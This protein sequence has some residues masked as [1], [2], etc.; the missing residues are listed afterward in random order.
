[1]SSLQQRFSRFLHEDPLLRRVLKNTGYLFTSST[2]SMVFVAVQSILAARLLGVE[3]LGVI[4]VAMTFVT[5][6][7]QLFSFRMGE[8]VVRYFG[9]AMAEGKLAHASATVKASAMVEGLTSIAAFGFL[10]L[11]APLG[12]RF[13]AKD[14]TSLILFQ[15]F[16]FAILANLV[17]ETANGVLRVLNHYKVQGWIT[18]IQSVLT[19]IIITLAFIFK[20]DVMTILLAYLI[21]KIFLGFSPVIAA[22][23][24]MRREVDPCWWSA[25]LAILPAL[26]DMTRFAISTNLSGTLKLVVSES[27]PFWVGLLLNT[28]AV[29]LYKVALAIVG[30]LIIPV[31]PFNFT[32]FP[33]ITRSV[34]SKGWKQ[35]RRLLKRVSALSAAWTI[36]VTLFMAVFGK[37][38]IGVTYGMEFKP[39][40][41][42]LMILLAGFG[43]SNIFFWNRSLLLSFGN[44]HVPLY[45]MA[46][47]GVLKI[48]LSLLL[49]PRFGM[50][51]EALLLSVYFI[52]TV[53]V[54]VAFGY[55]LIHKGELAE[56]Q[57][58]EA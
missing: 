9:A 44:A 52:M 40:Y 3:S 37:W 26:K 39:A 29:G 53:G 51:V 32:A 4:T 17:T 16:G 42:S 49:V 43:I 14:P 58:G 21:G 48:G 13:V 41:T 15:L 30:L 18:F 8:F 19:F 31:T 27:E 1:M 6:V 22:A 2:A 50:N 20:G 28:E 10:L 12:A 36:G 24:Y 11:V 46:G 56:T 54:M 25:R 7:N 5:M 35:L 57:A 33:E 45:V 38:L 55:G 34:A 23:F 47:A